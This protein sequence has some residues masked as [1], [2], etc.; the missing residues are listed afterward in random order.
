MT[1]DHDTDAAYWAPFSLDGRTALVTGAARGIGLAISHAL[2]RSG[3]SVVMTDI[4]AAEAERSAT[5]VGANP[6]R[7]GK[8]LACRLDVTSVASIGAA[9]EYAVGELGRIDIL[10]NNAGIN[11]ASDRV[12]IE[13]YREEDWRRILAV[14]LDGVFLVSRPV[15]EHMKAIGAGRI[16]NISSVLGIVP[17]RL[18][19]GYI[20]A[21]AA[22][23]ALTR[24]M[25]IELA[26]YGILV[27][28][29]APG[30]TLTEGTR[31]LFYGEDGAYSDRAQSLLSHIPLGRPAEPE[32]IASAVVYLA[33]PASSYVTGVVI[34]VDGGW[35][36]GY[37]R[38]W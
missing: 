8:A 17:A 24:S 5:E 29:V 26:P 37:L 33:A 27:N 10:V 18:Q 19:S 11:T 30:S 3:A 1:A 32:E 31:K 28:S 9:V 36:S 14:D 7:T 16:V 15:V 2:A 12:T 38:D 20:A 4:D 6:Y 21:K 13:R 22:V 25:A 35:S 23:I 34:P